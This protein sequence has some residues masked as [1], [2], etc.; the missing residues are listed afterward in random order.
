[1]GLRMLHALANQRR[2]VSQSW[3]RFW[4]GRY[5]AQ[6]L[7]DEASLLA[8]AAYVD[9][10]PVRA[11]IAKS[12]ETSEFTGAKDRIDD[13]KEG[14][15]GAT[16]GSSARGG[17]TGKPDVR[18]KRNART[19]AWERSRRRRKSDW[20]SPLEIAEK[21]DPASADASPCGRRASLK[22]FLSMPLTK[23]LEL[24]DW[25]GRQL[26]SGK[27]GT[28]PAELSPILERLGLDAVGWCDLV[29][30]F[31]KL[32]K[33]A[34]GAAESLS[35]EAARRGQRYLQAPVA[36]LLTASSGRSGRRLWH[37]FRIGSAGRRVHVGRCA[38]DPLHRQ[39]SLIDLVRR[40]RSDH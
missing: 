28:I 4:E 13:L 22:G 18:G 23:Y 35:T 11:A 9:L 15:S 7:L 34:A 19:H 20:M 32:F 30:K 6:L 39:E 38:T 26:R 37:S 40:H 14:E 10:N 27:R 24:L 17:Q 36:S 29:Q 8:C 33:R 2:L 1:L 21:S 31:G 12:I 25:T 3:G 16:V 5:Q